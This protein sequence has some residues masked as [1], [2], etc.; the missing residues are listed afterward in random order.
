M[1]AQALIQREGAILQRRARGGVVHKRRGRRW[2][3][4]FIHPAVKHPYI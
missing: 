1:A 3:S 2:D 4:A